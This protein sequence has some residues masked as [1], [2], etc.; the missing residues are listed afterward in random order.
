VS[1]QVL[2]VCD[3]LCITFVESTAFKKENNPTPDEIGDSSHKSSG[4]CPIPSHLYIQSIQACHPV[5]TNLTGATMSTLHHN[6]TIMQN[7]TS[8]IIN[9][10]L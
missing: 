5:R 7:N 1:I 10:N 9:H 3:V 2:P 6:I 4:R 8:I